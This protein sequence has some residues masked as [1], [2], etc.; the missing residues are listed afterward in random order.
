MLAIFVI[1]GHVLSRLVLRFPR[2]AMH[3]VCWGCAGVHAHVCPPHKVNFGTRPMPLLGNVMCFA[4][5][6]SEV[7]LAVRL[8]T[9]LTTVIQQTE[10][11][12]LTQRG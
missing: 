2:C 9:S 11:A 8:I 6:A 1:C 4:G 7:C 10:D 12:I 5:R 3:L